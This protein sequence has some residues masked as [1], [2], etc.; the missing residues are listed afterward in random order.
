MESLGYG[1][2]MHSDSDRRFQRRWVGGTTIG[3]VVGFVVGLNVASSSDSLLGTGPLQSVLAYSVAGGFVGLLVGLMQWRVL[4]RRISQSGAWVVASAAGLGIAGGAGYGLAVLIFGYS[5]DLEDLA[6]P[7]AIVGWTLVTACGGAIAGLLQWR[8]L[9][10][11]VR[12]AG[13]WVAASTIGWGLSTAA[14][15]TVVVA[16]F[17]IVGE[18]NPGILWFLAAILAAGIVLG[19]ITGAA[20]VRLLIEP[21]S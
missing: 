9:R 11:Q 10:S 13:S 1:P 7:A 17:R 8:V 18:A 15:G 5:R 4:R 19:V 3:W 2:T 14:M 20:I 16:S 12:Q 6:S 21:S